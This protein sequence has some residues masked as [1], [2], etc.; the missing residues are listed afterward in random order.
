MTLREAT[1]KMLKNR[2]E[3]IKLLNIANETG[4]SFYW[5]Q[6]FLKKGHETDSGSDKIVALYNYL[7]PV[8]LDYKD[9]SEEM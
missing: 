8:K 7:S 2:P 1:L 6:S 9:H 5:I 4:L 3:R